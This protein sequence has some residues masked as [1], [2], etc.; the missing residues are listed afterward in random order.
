MP[1]FG[2]PPKTEL[3]PF[4]DASSKMPA[5]WPH[6]NEKS[7]C[8]LVWVTIFC[9]APHTAWIFTLP[10]SGD[11]SSV[12]TVPEMKMGLGVGATCVGFC[13]V[14]FVM[15]PIVGPLPPWLPGPGPVEGPVG[16]EGAVVPP[17][18]PDAGAPPGAPPFWPQ[19]Q[20]NPIAAATVR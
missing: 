3:D 15:G 1:P 17:P 13:C 11:P 6:R 2:L 5:L 19:A 9:S 7:P 4:W 18:P 10:G 12:E 14:G 20:L 16:L 8:E